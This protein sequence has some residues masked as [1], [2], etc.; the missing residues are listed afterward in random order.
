[1]LMNKMWKIFESTGNIDAYLYYKAC[2]N[3]SKENEKEVLEFTKEEKR[4]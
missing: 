2:C 3:T 1:M 4:A